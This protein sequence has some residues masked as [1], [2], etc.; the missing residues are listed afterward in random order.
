MWLC[1]RVLE[2]PAPV[3]SVDIGLDRRRFL[4]LGNIPLE[5]ILARIFF[6]QRKALR[7]WRIYARSRFCLAS[8]LRKWPFLTRC[9]FWRFA[10]A[11]PRYLNDLYQFDPKSAHWTD[12]NRAF[13]GSPPSVRDRHTLTSLS[14]KL[15]IFGGQ[16]PSGC[17]D[18]VPLTQ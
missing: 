16:D 12:L 6:M 5:A 1:R 2:R 3:R 4:C 14:D 10:V 8:S 18:I 7:L 9:D 15:W 11:V 17:L 13:V